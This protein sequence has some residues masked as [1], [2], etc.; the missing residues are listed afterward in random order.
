MTAATASAATDAAPAPG[1]YAV[2]GNPVSHSRSPRIHALF[3]QQTG[4][5]LAY[6]LLPAPVDAFEATV[7][8]FFT[9]GG[10]GLNVTVPFKQE[11]HALAAAHL[12]PRAQLAG[13]VN[14]L[15]LQDGALHGCNTDGVGLVADLVRLGADLNGARVLIVG[16]GGAARGVLQPLAEAGCARIHIVNRTA[17]RAQAL[18]AEWLRATGA[19][20][21]TVSAGGLGDALK[22]GPWEVVVNATASSLADAAPDLPAGLYAEGALAYD[23]MYGPQPT[24]FMRQAATDGAALAADGLGMLVGQ[25]AESFFIWHGVRPDPEPVLAMLRQELAHAAP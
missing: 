1:R 22:G 6:E 18:A 19:P 4:I 24:P 20:S 10:K 9:G 17:E 12:S 2:I 5:A 21:P 8:G 23:M 11:A 15:W 7:R 16:A 14:T 3:G 25:A 13:A